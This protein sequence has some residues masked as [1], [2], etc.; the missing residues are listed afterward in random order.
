MVNAN[1]NA[2]SPLRTGT[3]SGNQRGYQTTLFLGRTVPSNPE[4]PSGGYV[5]EYALN[6][7]LDDVVSTRFPDGY[8]VL[9]GG[10][11]QWRGGRE[12]S[13]LLIILYPESAIHDAGT[14]IEEIRKIYK[15]R[16]AQESVLRVDAG[17]EFSF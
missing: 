14:K 5:H 16:F 13:I 12:S 9:S 8:T 4:Q 2:T 7:F 10:I 1:I 17:V 6:A 3:G 11:G 15:D